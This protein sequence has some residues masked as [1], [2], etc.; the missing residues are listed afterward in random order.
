MIHLLSQSEAER[1][2]I[3]P[4]Q[5]QSISPYANPAHVLAPPRHWLEALVREEYSWP[6]FR[7]RYKTLLRARFKEDPG[8]FFALLD[9]SDGASPLYLTCQCLSAPCH[10]AVAREFLENLRESQPR[11]LPPA[12]RTVRPAKRPFPGG[13]AARSLPSTNLVLA[14]L[15]EPPASAAAV[16]G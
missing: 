5:I 15:I 8:R 9:A 7:L 1:Q 11:P 3:R 6:F 13:H 12:I 16:H 4:S 2:D 14:T 10:R